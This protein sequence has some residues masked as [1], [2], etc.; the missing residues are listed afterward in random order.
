MLVALSIHLL[1]LLTVSL[2]QLA[3]WLAQLTLSAARQP[4]E[5]E[6]EQTAKQIAR[7]ERNG[8]E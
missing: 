4:R 7:R 2:M 6:R 5:V 8:A 1:W 3:A